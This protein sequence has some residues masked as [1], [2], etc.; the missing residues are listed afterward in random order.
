LYIL[1]NICY[2]L[3]LFSALCF[4]V[5]VYRFSWLL[6]LLEPE[7]VADKIVNAVLTS[8]EMLCLPRFLN[9]LNGLKK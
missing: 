2:Y 8:Q 9:V 1:C 4:I 6:P 3:L 5:P 7:Y